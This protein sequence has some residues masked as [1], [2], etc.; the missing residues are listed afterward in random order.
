MFA[1]YKTVHCFLSDILSAKFFW[2]NCVISIKGNKA[3]TGSHWQRKIEPAFAFK[4]KG[5]NHKCSN[6][7]YDLGDLDVC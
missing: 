1:T 6:K 4:V 2:G 7:H 3:R 5:L